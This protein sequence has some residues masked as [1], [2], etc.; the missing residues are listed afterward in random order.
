MYNAKTE[1]GS[2]EEQDMS[3]EGCKRLEV[4][5]RKV[6]KERRKTDKPIIKEK[7]IFDGFKEPKKKNKQSRQKKY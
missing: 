5:S 6:E 1:F 3:F 2:C 7:H 4:L